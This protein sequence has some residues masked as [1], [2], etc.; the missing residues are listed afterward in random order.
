[1]YK[2]IQEKI[3]TAFKELVE[4]AKLKKGDLIVFGCST[5]EVTGSRI[6]TNSQIDCAKMLYDSFY[7]FLKESGIFLAAQCCEHLERALVV[8]R[9]YAEKHNL[10]IVNAIPQPKAGGSSATTA[11]KLFDNPVLVARVQADAGIDVGG[12]L[13]GMHLKEVAVP[14]RLSVHKVGFA[15]IM[16]ARTRPRFV[17]GARAVYD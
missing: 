14:L 7:P 13:I 17:G 1:M 4:M 9:E 10:T 6:G 5:S 11:Y 12:T 15:R 8:E 2:E 16:C 3:L